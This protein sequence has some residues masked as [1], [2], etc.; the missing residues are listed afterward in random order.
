MKG[1]TVDCR[2]RLTFPSRH[3]RRVTCS[4]KATSSYLFDACRLASAAFSPD[5]GSFARALALEADVSR[6][7]RI[8]LTNLHAQT[9]DFSSSYLR[10]VA[11]R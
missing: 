3:R 9:N 6:W 1:S 7:C 10:T 2:T 4:I 11:F 8:T 5:N